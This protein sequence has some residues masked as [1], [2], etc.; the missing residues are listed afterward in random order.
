MIGN[1]FSIDPTTGQLKTLGKAPPATTTTDPFA[2]QLGQTGSTST[3]SGASAPDPFAGQTP[4]P[5]KDTSGFAQP[6]TPT[7][8]PTDT[9]ASA[10]TTD[11]KSGS[12]P[13][14]IVSTLQN[15]LGGADAPQTVIDRINNLF[16]QFA[17]QA[18]YYPGNNTIGLP[19]GYMVQDPTSK[20]WSFVAR[21]AGGDSGQ[22]SATSVIPPTGTAGATAIAQQLPGTVQQMDPALKAAIAQLLAEGN[23]PVS[24]Q[25]PII[26]GQVQAFKQ[27][28]DQSLR[29]LKASNAETA[30][31]EGT[32]TASTDLSNQRAQEVAGQNTGSFQA[33]LMGNELQNRRQQ[34]TQALQFAQGSDQQAL[35]LELANLNAAIA[36]QGIGTQNQQ[37]YDNLGVNTAL[38]Q[39]GLN[40]SLLAGLAGG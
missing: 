17:G 13:T 30:A 35:Q 9:S 20:Q 40:Q 14:D 22:P 37:F 24:A 7:P 27:Q 26:S 5:Q 11:T 28:Q 18:A 34:V 31:Y 38:D 19:T 29:D 1:P 4:T 33:T 23:T 21:G 8:A 6:T 15:Y 2:G 32:P 25:D 36:Q 39:A 16:P 3:G 12:A 10:P